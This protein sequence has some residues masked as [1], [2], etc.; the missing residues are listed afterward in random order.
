MAIEFDRQ[1]VTQQDQHWQEDS[2]LQQNL[3]SSN[4]I[5]FRDNS[6]I[7]IQDRFRQDYT[8]CQ[9]Y[10]DK[11]YKAYYN[12]IIEG[13]LATTA[14]S[15]AQ[16]VHVRHDN[17]A[18]GHGS[19]FTLNLGQW[20]YWNWALPMSA[21]FD[22]NMLWA[23]C[24][25]KRAHDIKIYGGPE[26]EFTCFFPAI[27][28]DIMYF[29]SIN[30]LEMRQ[31]LI[32]QR[33]DPTTGGPTPEVPFFSDI[34]L[35]PSEPYFYSRSV[36]ASVSVLN[37]KLFIIMSNWKVP[38]FGIYQVDDQRGICNLVHRQDRYHLTSPINPTSIVS[39][40]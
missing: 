39:P 13:S 5:G 23:T 32:C 12:S 6:I 38:S 36:V 22:N 26:N 19:M 7:F 21:V 17:R 24:I 1:D 34:E 9:F 33:I 18:H 3:L 4:Y 35:P 25:E 20:R 30:R 2:K 15:V 29:G 11:M 27:H 10:L 28:N 8:Y 31:R 16:L 40:D 37:G 14:K